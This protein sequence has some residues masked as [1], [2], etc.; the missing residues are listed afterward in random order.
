MW[1]YTQDE[2]VYDIEKVSAEGQATFMLLA[3]IQKRIEGLE[4]DLTINQAAAIA[5][6]EKMQGHL[7]DDAIVEDDDSED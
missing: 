1:R 5:L 2:K 6:H 7:T 3:E 4:E